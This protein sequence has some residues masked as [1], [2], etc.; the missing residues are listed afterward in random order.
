[1]PKRREDETMTT[2]QLHNSWLRTK[3]HLRSI[4]TSPRALR[5]ADR[6]LAQAARAANEAERLTRECLCLD[7]LAA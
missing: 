6:A 3:R 7:S 5:D 4:G 1:M 2:K